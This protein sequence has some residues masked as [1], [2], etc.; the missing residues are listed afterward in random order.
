MIAN[1][2]LVAQD[3]YEVCLFP[4]T[5]LSM[6]QDEG[7]DFSHAG[8]YNIDCVGTTSNAPLYAPCSMK[9]IHIYTDGHGQVWQ[10]LDKVHLPND[11]LDYF[12]IYCAHDNNPPYGVIGAE[13]NQG[14]VF[15]HTGTYGQVTGDHVHMCCGQGQNGQLVQRNTGNWDLDNRI[16][17]WNGLYVN[18]TTII[19]GYGHDWKE[20]EEQGG[21]K[22]WGTPRKA[23]FPFSV[24]WQHWGYK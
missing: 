16:H 3:G 9:L 1:E 21:G 14:E 15:Y 18:D 4:L 5:I 8:T 2:T 6:T 12:C 24:A 23:D 10:S 11:E 7:A 19:Q 13:V 20:W 22:I 17:A